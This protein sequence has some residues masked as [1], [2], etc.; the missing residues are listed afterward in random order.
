MTSSSR[1]LRAK[2]TD[3]FLGYPIGHPKHGPL[4]VVSYALNYGASIGKV[5]R[6]YQTELAILAAKREAYDQMVANLLY[7]SDMHIMRWWEPSQ[8]RL[9]VEVPEKEALRLGFWGT[10]SN[11]LFP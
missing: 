2:L 5:R 7:A 11:W 1:L 8:V 9:V 10:I 4:K 6:A 3:A